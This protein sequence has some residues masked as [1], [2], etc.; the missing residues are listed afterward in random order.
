MPYLA[1]ICMREGGGG[2]RSQS[3]MTLSLRHDG[4]GC[5]RGQR[6]VYRGISYIEGYVQTPI[7]KAKSP[8][9]VRAFLTR[10]GRRARRRAAP[11]R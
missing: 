9:P 4:L 2:G 7:V 11:A 3:G 10:N 5:R 1:L 6:T 8:N